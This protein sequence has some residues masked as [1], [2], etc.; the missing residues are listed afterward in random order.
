MSRM[1]SVVAVQAPPRE[2][3]E[4]L[5][6]FEAEVRGIASRES[7]NP[8]IVVY[9]EL[10]L[11]GSE[12]GSPET[13]NA[14]LR[15]SA[16]P[17][18][19]PLDDRLRA[20]AAEL[21]I[22]LLPGSVCELGPNGELFNTAVVYSPAGERVASYRKM[23]PWRPYEPYE[24]G[25][26]FVVF[27]IP[28]VGRLGLSICYD[29]W[30]PELT[31]HLAWMGAEVVLNI[32]KTTTPDREQELVL[33]RANSIVN[34]VVT[35]SVNCAGPVG[36]GRS[37]V[38]DAEGTVIEQWAD[39]APATLSHVI[40]F[41]DVARVRALGTAGLNRVWEQFRP[42]DHPIDL[43]LYRGRL[44]PDRWHPRSADPE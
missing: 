18:D 27:D 7:S 26:D 22:W 44:E 36:M 31:R 10:H 20:L 25:S 21:D 12:L 8:R 2:I 30:F 38:V 13:R 19:G 14:H 32:V 16:R 17:L 39:D 6:A 4:P 24:P 43:P 5:D 33:A 11:F 35:V 9:P 41:D 37:I 42:T 1:L 28:A 34:Q 40:D 23:F 3:G 29:A 15:A